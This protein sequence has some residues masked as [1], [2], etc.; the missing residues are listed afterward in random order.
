MTALPGLLKSLMNFIHAHGILKRKPNHFNINFFLLLTL[1]ISW[2]SFYI[3]GIL[4]WQMLKRFY[5]TSYSIF[6]VTYINSCLAF[7]SKHMCPKPQTCSNVGKGGHRK[8]IKWERFCI[9]YQY[10]STT[11]HFYFYVTNFLDTEYCRTFC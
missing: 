2:T 10:M 8:T 3:T 7:S 4:C 11:C 5:F 9:I 1:C 6:T